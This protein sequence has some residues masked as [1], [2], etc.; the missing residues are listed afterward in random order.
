[1]RTFERSSA[2]GLAIGQQGRLRFDAIAA[3]QLF[4]PAGGGIQLPQMP[5]ID[6]AGVAGVDDA[7]PV[8]AGGCVFNLECA[9]CQ[10]PRFAASGRHG[11]EM[12]PAIVFGRKHDRLIP[13]PVELLLGTQGM[14][15]AARAFGCAVDLGH[16]AV[17]EMGHADRPG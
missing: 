13:A 2:D 11:V 15:N 17:G 14:E 1:M 12:Q 5:A 6:V 7:A 4:E 10:Q 9:G 16:A 3:R 8:D